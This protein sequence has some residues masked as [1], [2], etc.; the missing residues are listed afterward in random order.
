MKLYKNYNLEEDKRKPKICKIE[1]I[2]FFKNQKIE[3]SK[4]YKLKKKKPYGQ[5]LSS[6]IS[7]SYMQL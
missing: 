2:F 1:N 4:K 7:I 5:I 6:Q 3:I